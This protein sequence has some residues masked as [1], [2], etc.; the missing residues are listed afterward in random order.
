MALSYLRISIYKLAWL[1]K[2]TFHN[3]FFGP[4]AFLQDAVIH[5]KWTQAFMAF[6][7]GC[8]KLQRPVQASL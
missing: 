3:S 8:G 7:P 5:S 6:W 2:E 4:P 1:N